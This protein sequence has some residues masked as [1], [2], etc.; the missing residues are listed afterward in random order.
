MTTVKIPYLTF[1]E[2]YKFHIMNIYKKIY[3]IT[4]NELQDRWYT[5]VMTQDLSIM[6]IIDILIRRTKGG[7]RLLVNRN[8]TIALGSIQVVSVSGIIE[9]I[10]DL[11]VSMP[12]TIL[13]IFGADFDGDVLAD[14]P[15]M[16]QTFADKLEKY[17]SPERLIISV[18]TGL[19]NRRISLIKD[20]LVGL[21]SFCN[22]PFCAEDF[23]YPK[24]NFSIITPQLLQAR[25]AHYGAK[26]AASNAAP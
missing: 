24:H 17:Y 10:T 25:D 6:H 19:Y 11:T 16:D 8:P 22:D 18:N 3:R 2:F 23:D 9:D 12:L 13:K 15:I 20:Q 14:I 7:L 26:M 5:L 1:C 4:V 21:Y